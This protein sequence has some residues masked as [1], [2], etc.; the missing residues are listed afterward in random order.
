MAVKKRTILVEH[1]ITC[2]DKFCEKCVYLLGG[3][4][5]AVNKRLHYNKKA[6]TYGSY[7]RHVKCIEG[8]ITKREKWTKG[9]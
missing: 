1:K 4:C 3:E 6:A 8:E 7:R 9:K 5:L 2:G